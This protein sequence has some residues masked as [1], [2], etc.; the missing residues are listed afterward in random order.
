MPVCRFLLVGSFVAEGKSRKKRWR[1]QTT[2]HIRRIARKFWFEA[3]PK[4]GFEVMMAV[5]YV[6]FV[7]LST[8]VYT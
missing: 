7:S 4:L 5:M 2:C 6:L 3:G 1:S 8:E